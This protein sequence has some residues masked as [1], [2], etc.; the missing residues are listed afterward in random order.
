MRE[1]TGDVPMFPLW[2][3]GYW[4]SKERYKSEVCRLF[5]SPDPVRERKPGHHA[6]GAEQNVHSI[7]AD[8]HS[9]RIP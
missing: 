7:R 1:L 8:K 4:Q 3:Y 9:K 5:P 6:A 2:T